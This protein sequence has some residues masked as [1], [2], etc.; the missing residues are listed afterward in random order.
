MKKKFKMVNLEC[1]NCASKME[2]RIKKLD[3]VQDATISFMTQK[4]IVDLDDTKV[5]LIV[6]EISAVC[7]KIEPNCEV[8]V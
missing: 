5:D 8:R 1:A 3:G 6:R 4:L 2:A 7:K